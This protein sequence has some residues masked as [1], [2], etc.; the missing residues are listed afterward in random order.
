METSGVSAVGAFEVAVITG[1]VSVSRV[2]LVLFSSLKDVLDCPRPLVLS[3]NGGGR[4][5]VST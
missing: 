3:G 2:S 4:L 1:S 5:C